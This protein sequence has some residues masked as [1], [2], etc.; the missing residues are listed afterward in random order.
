MMDNV[1]KQLTDADIKEFLENAALYAWREFKM[2]DV[3]RSSL[4]INEIDAFCETCGQPRPFQSL[5]STGGGVVMK[6][7]TTV[8]SARTNTTIAPLELLKTGSTHFEFTCA[9]C[10]IKKHRYFVEHIIEGEKISIQKYGELPRM[11][12]ARDRNLQRFLKDDLENYEKAFVCLSHEYGIAAFAYLR[13]IIENNIFRLL[14][15]VQEDA[16][17][18]AAN[19]EIIEALGELRK[20]SPMSEK[21]KIANLALPEHLKPD[22]LNPLGRLYQTLSEGV[23]SLSDQECLSKAKATCECLAFLVSELTSRKERRTRF[24]SLVGEL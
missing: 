10:R 24:K 5:R 4:H 17:S 22:G 13:R 12:L 16:Q 3:N 1:M 15:L 9:S 23:H 11:K 6:T 7:P 14:D 19:P 2:P 18:A 8:L 21:I 20:E